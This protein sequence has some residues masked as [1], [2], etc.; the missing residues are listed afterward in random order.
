M[1]CDTMRYNFTYIL[2]TYYQAIITVVQALEVS[3]PGGNLVGQHRALG[4]QEEEERFWARG[5]FEES[6]SATF[7]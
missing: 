2:S 7:P 3:L 6:A 5:H 4:V 1:R